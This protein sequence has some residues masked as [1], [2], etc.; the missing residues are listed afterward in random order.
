[1]NKRWWAFA[2]DAVAVYELFLQLVKNT[3][4]RYFNFFEQRTEQKFKA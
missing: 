1:M 2:A 4:H 3:C